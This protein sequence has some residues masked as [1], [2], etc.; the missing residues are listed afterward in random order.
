MDDIFFD[1]DF[2]DFDD[3]D[4]DEIGNISETYTP[5]EVIE[6]LNGELK[7]ILEELNNGKVY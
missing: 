6:Y 4:T 5:E 2:D 7:I 1:D 3:E